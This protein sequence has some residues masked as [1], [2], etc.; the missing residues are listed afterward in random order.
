MQLHDDPIVPVLAG[1]A[2]LFLTAKVLGKAATKLKQP[3]VLGELVAGLL[4]GSLPLAG[5][6]A[7]E[8]IKTSEVFEV[9]AGIGVILL[10]FEVGLDT[11][12]DQLRRV[13]LS[14]TLVAVIGV[15]APMLLGY[16]L[17]VVLLPEHSF[18]AHLF[19]GAT[20][21]ATSVGITARVFKDLGFLD[22]TEA[23]IILGAAVIDDIL[24]LIVLAVVQ[25]M[26]TAASG[27]GDASSLWSDVGTITA[28]AFVFLG[29]ALF[30]G[31]R[32]APHVFRLFGRLKAEGML[33][34]L[35]LVLCFLLAYA[36]AMAGLAPI[37]GA[38][39]AG[40]IVD[41]KGFGKFFG[42]QEESLEE[43]I[44]PV[45]QFFV[46]LFFVTMGMK[47]DLSTL[48]DPSVLGLGAALSVVAFVSKQ[49]CGLA[50]FGEKGLSRRLVGLG[51]VP[52]GEVGLIFAMIGSSLVLGS[53]KII[54]DKLYSAIIIMIMFTTMITPLTLKW[55]LAKR[56]HPV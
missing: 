6:H 41:G 12:V 43:L 9:M 25:G 1:L 38:F 2:A 17:G 26:I 16:G 19:L 14:A 3:A 5:I 44:H 37:V 13:G 29:V 7:L 28:K 51:M 49:V 53:E 24:G 52:R 54:D 35:A 36:A 30:V 15:V 10:L 34:T 20:L 55:S 32:L 23:K 31:R 56:R 40:L 47:V 33:L 22:T 48:A 21:C 50:A 42:G 39:A 27:S 18:Y 8:F 11:S 45:S 46:P 4:L